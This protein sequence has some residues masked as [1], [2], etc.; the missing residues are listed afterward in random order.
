MP[1]ELQTIQ[2]TPSSTKPQPSGLTEVDQTGA[3][4][5]A[6]WLELADAQSL[7]YNRDSAC[8]QRAM[9]RTIED[10]FTPSVAASTNK[11]RGF[12]LKTFVLDSDYSS[13]F[14]NDVQPPSDALI[15]HLRQQISSYLDERPLEDGVIHP[16]EAVVAKALTGGVEQLAALLLLIETEMSAP[17]FSAAM[18][19]LAGR[20]GRNAGH[21]SFE[22]I[23]DRAL[24]SSSPTLREAAVEAVEQ[25]EDPELLPLLRDHNEPLS[26]LKDYIE[27]VIE[28]LSE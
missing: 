14:P 1:P 5:L 22:G 6:A 24:R 2:R 20:V 19:R 23:I 21:D 25:W 12:R 8:A 17:D 9:I 26:W 27:A 10:L 4:R 18:L 7:P 28:D 15:R 13:P 3:A 16:A 11:P